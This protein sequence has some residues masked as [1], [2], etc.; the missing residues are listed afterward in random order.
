MSLECTFHAQLHKQ[1]LNEVVISQIYWYKK[2]GLLERGKKLSK[3]HKCFGQC[4]C[5]FAQ[6]FKTRILNF[7]YFL[8]SLEFHLRHKFSKIGKNRWWPC[9]FTRHKKEKSQT[10]EI[11][12]KKPLV[13]FFI[14]FSIDATY[15]Y[16]CLNFFRI[17]RI[18]FHHE[19][20]PLRLN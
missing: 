20:L 5:I 13:N 12:K 14:N 10:S 3:A 16:L 2:E 17:A 1:W 11:K 19:S 4:F 7:S 6:N 18:F 15:F 8:I 9:E